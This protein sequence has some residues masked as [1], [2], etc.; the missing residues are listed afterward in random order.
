MNYIDFNISVI[1][2]MYIS[3]ILKM[4][5][6]FY[7]LFLIIYSLFD[8]CVLFYIPNPRKKSLIVHHICTI[9]LTI[10]TYMLYPSYSEYIYKV[11][12]IEL[13]SLTLLLYKKFKLKYIKY[14]SYV[15]WIYQRSF[16][17]PLL[18]SNIYSDILYNN[19]L[20]AIFFIIPPVLIVQLL[21]IYWTFA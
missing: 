8:F 4:D 16:Y 10:N 19:D 5:I 21:S 11:S 7:S 18:I 6:T 20:S 15:L 1:T 14:V 17:L 3:N 2:T 9:L 12:S 13:S